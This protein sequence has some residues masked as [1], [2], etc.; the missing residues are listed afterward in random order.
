[1]DRPFCFAVAMPISKDHAQL[2]VS[3]VLPRVIE[4]LVRTKG[5][6]GL[7]PDRAYQLVV[8]TV[9]D[10]L[11]PAWGIA[12]PPPRDRC[13]STGGTELSALIGG[14]LGNLAPAEIGHVYEYLR[15][16]KIV[17]SEG[18]ILA[19]VPS[20]GSRRNQGLFYTPGPVVRHIVS[21]T[22]DALQ[23]GERE[24]LLDVRILDPAV[25]TGLFLVE[26]LNE[27][28]ARVLA[29]GGK[30]PRRMA[31]RIRE[32]RTRIAAVLSGHCVPW[33]IED[34]TAVRIHLLDRCLFGVDLDPVALR[35]ARTSLW[36][37]VFQG[38][39]PL[40]GF[41][42]NIRLGN[43]LIGQQ[44]GQA[45]SSTRQDLDRTHA[46][47]FFGKTHADDERI[48]QW[49]VN[50][51]VLHWPLEYPEIFAEDQGGF[52]AV[53]GNPP[54]E[55]VSVKESGL[56]DRRREQ[57]YFR[58]TYRTCSGKINTYRLMLERGLTLL[59]QG[60]VLGFIVPAT[61]LADSTAGPLRRVILDESELVES[62]FIPEK[63]QVFESVTQAVLI[64]VTRKGKP[65][66]S[67]SPVFW[68]G[69]GAVSGRRGIRISRKL[70]EQSGL[71]I[72]LL[73]S[74]EEKALLE[75]TTK[76]P[77][78]GGNAEFEAIGHAHQGEINLTTQRWFITSQ[79]TNHPLVRGEHVLPFR[80]AHPSARPGRWDWVRAE[81]LARNEGRAAASNSGRGRPWESERIVVGR[82]VNMATHRRL[83]AATVPP[84]SFLGDMTNYIAGPSVPIGY[85]IALLNSRVL[86]WR[87][88]LTSTN[89]YLSALE[90]EA[91]PIPRIQ[92]FADRTD[93]N[94]Q[95]V[96][97]CT[98]LTA[99]ASG[100]LPEC[101]KTIGE[102]LGK[103]H[104]VPDSERIARILV[105]IVDHALAG[106]RYVG[107]DRNPDERMAN[108][109]DAL[110]L[111]LFE[112]EAFVTVLVG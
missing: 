77:P 13:R 47:A 46:V 9:V 91:L 57:T 59:R 4:D 84:G 75:A 110:V 79:R 89:N 16:F 11:L 39:P 63:A 8:D 73:R 103:R 98:R 44:G 29:G 71:R 70:M 68:E 105:W 90:V 100:S 56:E 3:D 107:P 65:T 48:L 7:A 19:V 1:M 96:Q 32:I 31:D 25:G 67:F 104:E 81:F 85:L 111:K 21:R 52:D 36:D 41:E 93:S 97:E 69:R 53:I 109:L 42:P 45:G 28:T 22:L 83:K 101:L 106:P 37:A 50:K 102:V 54:Y 95:F 87:I 20:R 51:A 78:L 99:A 5:L 64:M 62:V 35:I 108:L 66:R 30:R 14:R 12:D 18:G 86:N 80:V 112:A 24:D 49:A 27:I 55:I 58:R 34:E 40:P 76:H 88:K 15:S 38:R 94:G 26:A 17:P 72:P 33:E 10:A 6:A 61:L 23:V 2:L 60:G 74:A 43:S 82:V 92:S